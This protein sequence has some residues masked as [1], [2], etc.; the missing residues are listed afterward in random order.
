MGRNETSTTPVRAPFQFTKYVHAGQVSDMYDRNQ[1]VEVSVYSDT[2]A[3][4]SA[5]PY[6]DSSA[7]GDYAVVSGMTVPL[8]LDSSFVSGAVV[9]G[10]L[11]RLPIKGVDVLLENDLTDKCYHS[12]C[13][14]ALQVKSS[15]V[16]I[17]R[18]SELFEDSLT[19]F[20]ACVTTRSMSKV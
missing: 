18:R 11:D 20:P 13:S 6:L 17:D 3:L 7:T 19:V 16:V 1:S 9:V 2:G 8:W 10:V 14:T 12:G 15:P 4:S 5:V